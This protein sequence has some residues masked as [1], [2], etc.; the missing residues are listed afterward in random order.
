MFPYLRFNQR[1]TRLLSK[2]S[3][4]VARTSR[5]G[6]FSGTK[7][8]VEADGFAFADDLVHFATR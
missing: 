4:D 6:G 5:V 1:Y 2:G 3:L 8:V 7:P